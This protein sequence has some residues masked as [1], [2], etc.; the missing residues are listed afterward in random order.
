MPAALS[1]LEEPAWISQ[2]LN[3][4]AGSR[5]WYAHDR[6]PSEIVSGGGVNAVAHS[7]STTGYPTRQS[8]GRDRGH[9]PRLSR[10]TR[11]SSR[12]SASV[13]FRKLRP[14]TEI[15]GPCEATIT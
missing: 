2:S 1:Q 10:T 15:F 12:N 14:A 8:R 13:R 9:H 4:R 11:S 5:V 6:D 7:I 3:P